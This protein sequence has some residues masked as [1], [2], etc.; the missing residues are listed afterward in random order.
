MFDLIM[1]SPRILLIE[2]NSFGDEQADRTYIA[3]DFLQDSH[4]PSLS[5]YDY[6]RLSQFTH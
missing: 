5:F 3:F 6:A 2:F 1:K 4:S